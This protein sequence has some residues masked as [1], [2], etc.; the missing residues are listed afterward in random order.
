[1]N[2]R[3]AS[4]E[5]CAICAWW[6]VFICRCL[7]TRSEGGMCVK[8]GGKDSPCAGFLSL[9]K[10]TPIIIYMVTGIC[11]LAI[12]LYTEYTSVIP[13]TSVTQVARSIQIT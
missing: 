4:S 9:I 5:R 7:G 1:M 13:G 12:L 3:L 8:C 10:V 2:S 6:L 11:I